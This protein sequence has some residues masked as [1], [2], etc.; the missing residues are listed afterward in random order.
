[1]TD[2]DKK[3]P[4][5]V[6][7]TLQYDVEKLVERNYSTNN[8]VEKFSEEFFGMF[9]LIEKQ[10]DPRVKKFNFDFATYTIDAEIE[11]APWVKFE[12]KFTKFVND[13]SN[14]ISDV[15]ARIMT[16]DDDSETNR[17]ATLY[18]AVKFSHSLYP[19]KGKAVFT[20]VFGWSVL[21]QWE[22]LQESR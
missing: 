11:L 20:D 15:Q 16:Y 22:S 10:E 6:H 2:T 1:M 3:T 12:E 21:E 7:M 8:A 14:V 5:T 18:T 13:Y 19:V 4:P 9:K 17:E